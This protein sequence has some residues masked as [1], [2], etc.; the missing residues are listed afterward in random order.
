MAKYISIPVTS[1]PQG[2][3]FNSDL[4][5]T[6]VYIDASNIR[7]WAYGKSYTFTATGTPGATAMGNFITAIN[8]AITASSGPLLTS[9]VMPTGVV[10]ALPPTVA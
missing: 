9:V 6:T 7:I 2:V 5:T 8:T 10:V 3:I 1:V 4:I